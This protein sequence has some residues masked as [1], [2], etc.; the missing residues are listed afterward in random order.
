MQL[1]R[2]V[3]LLAFVLLAG[4]TAWGLYGLFSGGWT[5]ALG[6]WRGKGLWLLGA[7]ACMCAGTVFDLLGWVWIYRRLGIRTW[8]ATGMGVFLAAQAGLLLPLQL[9]RLVRPDALVRLERGPLGVCLKAEMAVLF[10]DAAAAGVLFL[11]LAACWLHPLLGAIC[12]VVV[13]V[14]LLFSA[15]RLAA[16]L[17]ETRVALPPSFWRQWQTFAVLLLHVGAWTCN[18]LALYLV[19][20]DLPGGVSVPE[21]LF[22]APFSASVGAGTGLPGGIGAIEGLL[23]IS[24][25][26]LRVP[27]AHL[28]LA[29]GAY[30]LV[31]F[32]IWLP[33]GWLAL[34]LTNRKARSATRGQDPNESLDAS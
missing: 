25:K 5:E 14:V 31:S 11:G 13:P 15:D 32:W 6:Y 7:F 29:V 24:L 4:V 27:T 33:I 1:K 19:V 18:G 34:L 23:G 12:A 8:D 20:R 26:T 2:H 9:G 17:S 3:R 16:M 21:A 10:L 28:A 30:R 22:V